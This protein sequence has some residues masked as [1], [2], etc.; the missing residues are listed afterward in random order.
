MK[1]IM[2]TPR[3]VT[4]YPVLAFIP[5]WIRALAKQ[6]DRLWVVSPRVEKIP[7]PENVRL[8][9]VGRDY[10]HG[11]TRFHAL[12]NFHRT[13]SGILREEQID[14][15]F[16]HMFPQ[17]AILAAPYTK[18]NRIPLVLWYTHQ[19]VSVQL[20]VAALV[21]D[22]IL[23]ASAETCRIASNKVKAIG[24][25]IDTDHF[26]SR[27]S[28]NP[29]TNILTSVGRI[30]PVKNIETMIEAL[31]ILH[32]QPRFSEV[33]LRLAGEPASQSQV[34]Y[35]AELRRMVVRLNLVPYVHF[36]GKIEHKNLPDYLHSCSIFI[37]SSNSGLDKAVLEAMAME[38]PVIVSY[39]AMQPILGDLAQSL[40]FAPGDAAGLADRLQDIL[41]C[42]TTEREI[43]GSSLRQIVLRSHNVHTLMSKVKTTFIDLQTQR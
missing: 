32:R 34:E 21:V 28:G 6:V 33:Q 20:R 26:A 12:N 3:V 18:R 1:L 2:I 27:S 29:S 31:G 25:G 40:M 37:S 41:T 14:G 39:P 43:L 19:H 38:K 5:G 16:A 15:V 24:H 17:F 30:S 9:Q 35:L 11:E 10:G 36:I 8:V 13:I 4:S 22:R 23:T 42:P 7:M